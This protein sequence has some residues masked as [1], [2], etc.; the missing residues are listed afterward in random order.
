MMLP[1]GSEGTDAARSCLPPFVEVLR[2]RGDSGSRSFALLAF[3]DS[4]R[5]GLRL[6][7]RPFS[8]SGERSSRTVCARACR[9]VWLSREG[10]LRRLLVDLGRASERSN[11]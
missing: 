10:D 5:R 7:S 9:A 3:F 8:F 4:E 2:E 1:I 11:I 6:R